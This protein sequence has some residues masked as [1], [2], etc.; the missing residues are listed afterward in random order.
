MHRLAL[1]LLVLPFAL[2]PG[3]RAREE[4]PA[5]PEDLVLVQKGTLPIIVSAPH[6]GR[7][8]IPGVTARAGTGVTNFSVAFDTNTLELAELFAAAL[9]KKLDGKPWLVLA[10]FSRQYLDPN[11]PRDGSYESDKA[12]PYYD[13]YHDSLEAACKA[14]KKEFGRGLLL[15]LHGQGEFNDTICRGTQNGKTVT[16]LKDRYGWPAVTG[17]RS[18]LGHMERRGY[19]VLPNCDADEK[20]K[21]EPKFNGGYIVGNYGSH[22]GYAIDAIQLEFGIFLREKT[23]NRFARTADDLA[24]AVAIFH[25]EYLKD[26]K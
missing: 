17:K 11:R 14:V 24:D 7:K 22:T 16:V 15:D 2:L 23:K 20:T 4:P 8:A 12:K 6:G 21:E 19:K 10:R 1:L 25:D 5:K 13:R 18:V 3:A 26:A 9:E